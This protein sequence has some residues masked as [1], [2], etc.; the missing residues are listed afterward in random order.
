MKL[1]EYKTKYLSKLALYEPRNEREKEIKDLIMNKLYSI[2][3]M[4]LPYL[5]HTLYLA[6]EREKDISDELKGI[7]EEMI[8][9]A[10]E[11]E[12]SE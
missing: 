11:I 4:T 7:F 8:A 2:R 6:I 12:S 10:G 3:T 1:Y 5:V 9:D